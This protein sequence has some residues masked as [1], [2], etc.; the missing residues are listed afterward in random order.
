MK[1][2][3][4]VSEQQLD[5]L[6]AA[7]VGRGVGKV[8]RGVAT[9]VGAVAGGI[10][11]AGKAFMKGFKQGKDFVGGPDEE[12]AAKGA[13]PAAAPGKPA[14]MPGKTA[15]AAQ[16]GQAAPTQIPKNILTAIQKLDA[17]KKKELLGML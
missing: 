5:E 11:G 8:A 4:L 9:G 2:N 15:P 13:A 1:L 7:D 12:P 10:A 3:E 17:P 6:T 16:G 14:A